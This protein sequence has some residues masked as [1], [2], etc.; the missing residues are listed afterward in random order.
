M[1]TLKGEVASLESLK[2]LKPILSSSGPCLSVYMPLSTAS[3]AGINPNAKQNDLHWRECVRSLEPRITQL[4][5]EAHE[6]LNSIRR[7]DD[8]MQDQEPQGRSV[9]VFRSP[10]VFR[11]SWLDNEVTDRVVA[12]PHFYIRPLLS[13]LTQDRSFYILALS[14]RKVR[15]L[16]C[17]TR[18]SEE[19]PLPE[20]TATSW[21]AFM[22][23]AEPDHVRDNRASPGPSSGSS[24]GVMFGTV[25]D[26]E[27]WNEYMGHFFKQI[28]RGVNEVLRGHS[29]PVVLAAVE[30]E[31]PV[32]RAVN[33]YPHLADEMVRGAPDGLRGGEMHARALDA[34]RRCYDKEIDSAMGEWNHKVGGAASSRL[35]EV[36]TA[37]HEGRVLTLLVS[38]SQEKTGVFDE[39]TFTVK[40]RETGTAEDEDLVNDAAVQTIIHA[41]KIY[42]VPHNKMPNGAAVAAVFRFATAAS[43]G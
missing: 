21:E 28:D 36:V 43:R 42:V 3:T 29:E 38:D 13:E 2:D 25:T 23:T 32:Y 41:G 4:G 1:N 6:L 12:G 22:N 40:G 17:T 10:D 24:P 31:L 37:A 19:I 9:V 35:K 27:D 26:T 18:T 15:L 33:T 8:I 30:Y 16:H 14:Q 7:W 39:T 20:S 34:L 5:G 11:V